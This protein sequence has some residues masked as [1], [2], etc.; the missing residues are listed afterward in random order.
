MIKEYPL[1]EGLRKFLPEGSVSRVHQYFLD[2]PIH[3]LL[4][5]ERKT[6]LGD[7]RHPSPAK[8]F[9]RI[10]VNG[11]LNPY[12]FLV[13]LL[14]EIAHMLVFVNYKRRVSPHGP[15]WKST[16]QTVLV[17]FLADHIF[18]VDVERALAD[19]LS[20]PAAST[21]T[22][23]GLYKALYAYDEKEAGEVMVEDLPMGAEFEDASGRRF[24]KLETRRTR[25]KCQE[26]STGRY[27]LFSGIAAVKHLEPQ[28][29]S[30]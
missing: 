28:K 5:R 16:F 23:P 4:T 21:C 3:L 7:Y 2:Y 10:S 25:I 19:Y 29:K 26:I 8:P 17:P 15:E 6:V 24:V 11:N 20:N 14:H 30:V 13:T 9:H 1:E 18:P 12:S 22:D 27:F